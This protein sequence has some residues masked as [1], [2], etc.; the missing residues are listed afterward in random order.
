MNMKKLIVLAFAALLAAPCFAQEEPLYTSSDGKL[1][2]DIVD[3]VGFGYNAVK[4]A[5]F[6]P[7]FACDLFMNVIKIG[8]Y[9]V[10]SLGLELGV[11][12]EYN[13]F[14]AK[15][16]A[17]VQHDGI[18]KAS[19]FP[20]LDAF[21][22]FDRKSSYFSV[23]GLSAPVLVKGIFGK[24]EIGAGA[25]A[26]WNITGGTNYYL[27]TDKSELNYYERKAKVNPFSYGI[28]AMLSYNE[29]GLFFKYYPKSSHILPE[30]SVDLSYT[31]IGLAISL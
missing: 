7:G 12:V 19:P 24:F 2:F 21:G 15:E 20:A 27:R 5:D 14:S 3:H 25:V 9:P 28:L 8:L 26:S 11:D 4:S 10:E 31:T 13:S 16:S 1:T 6:K 18:I 17:F 29:F 30:G 23:F 22:S